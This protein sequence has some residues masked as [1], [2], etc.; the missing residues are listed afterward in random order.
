MTNLLFQKLDL[1]LFAD[2]GAGAA[3]GTGAEGATGATAA[4]AVPQTKG[5]KSNPLA[6]VVYG[7][8]DDGVQA[9]S[10]QENAAGSDPVQTPDLDAEFEEL[11]KGKYKSQY[12]KRTQDTIQKRLKGS[13]E[14]ESKLKALAPTLEKLAQKYGVDASDIEAL[15]K[16]IEDDDTYYEQEA[17]EK[18]VTVEQ[19][20]EIRKM[21]KENAELK[22]QMEEQ[23]RKDNANKIYAQ[24][25]EQ[26]DSAK[27]VY[28][29]FDLRAEMQ[30][31][32]FVDLLR[33]NIDVRTAYEVIHKDDIIAGAMQFTA[34]TVE[35][36][37]ANKIIA[38]GARPAENGNSSQGAS[39][40]KSDVSTLTKADLA[41]IN[42]RVA[43]GEKIS[44]G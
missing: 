36:K 17:L 38:G 13:K 8:Q 29:T 5:A 3:G 14:N 44:F 16:A 31:P 33:S 15:N 10:A 35:Q 30:N 11:I 7:K 43:R 34:K 28:P 42:R 32:K 18:G 25:M 4:A 37:I 40:T 2:G 9:A 20:K 1:Q 22:K 23:N 6:G 19:L 12:D 39:V 24:W 26:A 21:E 41:E 27:Q